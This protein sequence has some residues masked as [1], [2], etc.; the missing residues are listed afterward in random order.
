MSG[1]T[2]EQAHQGNAIQVSSHVWAIPLTF[3]LPTAGGSAVPRLVHAYI[4]RGSQQSAV[5]DCGTA[6]CMS[7]VVA[8]IEAAS[9]AV[10]HISLLVATHEHADHMGAAQLLMRHYGWRVAAHTLA[11]RWLEDAALQHSE[12]PLLNFDTLM[13]GSITV[14]QPLNEGDEIDVGGCRMRVLYTPGHSVGSQS[15]VVEPD[16]VIITGD[17]LISAV[18]APFYDN[19]SAV[20]A[21]VNT[22]RRES[23]GGARRLLS[24]HA[25]TPSLVPEQALDDTLALLERMDVAVRQAR[26]E[27]GDDAEDALVR[28]ALDLGG[29][30]QQAVMPL[31]R[32]T[33]RSHL[34]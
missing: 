29:W 19:P 2:N 6:A 5:V 28:R 23:A 1:W 20:R 18:A 10:G 14:G 34:V 32:I 26:L 8:G 12:R 3:S 16:G 31:T 27:V 21:S 15:L 17:V 4:V 24:S 7:D 33:V 22:L 30:P 13:A 11:R 9:L 25:P